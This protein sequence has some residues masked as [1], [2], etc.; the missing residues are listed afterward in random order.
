MPPSSPAPQ[1]RPVGDD[2][3]LVEYEAVVSPEVNQRVHRL[4]RALERDPIPGTLEVV[5]AYRSLMIYFNPETSDAERIGA[6][7]AARAGSAT[8][9]APAPPHRFRLP[10]V[11]GGEFGPD[12]AGVAAATGRTEAEVIRGFCAQSYP[13]YFLGNLCAL[14][15]LG[16]LP[17]ALSL[18]RRTTPRLR[19]AAGSVGIANTQAVVLPIDLPSGWHY[20]GRTF[21]TIYDPTRTP[22]SPF[23]PDDQIEFPA[24]T[25][26]EARSA[27]GRW[28]GD[29]L[30]ES[31]A[32]P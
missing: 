22:P 31:A 5:T 6:G 11:Y 16:G 26:S 24:V 20:L 12:L 28:A 19:V 17:E 15:Y 14:P 13:V 21:A 29:Y 18:P 4:A 8:L 3:V 9:E 1:S 32:H 7:V 30:S 10:T 2:A 25:E 27:A 23:R